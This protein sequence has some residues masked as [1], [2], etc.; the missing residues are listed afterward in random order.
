M[1]VSA[2]VT[3]Y[4]EL[5]AKLRASKSAATE[6]L[7]RNV[8]TAADGVVSQANRLTQYSVRIPIT[9]TSL[10]PT[11]ARITTRGAGTSKDDDIGAVIENRGKGDVRHPTFGNRHKWT[12]KNSHPEFM[13]AAL[14]ARER[15]SHDLITSSLIEALREVDL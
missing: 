3:S 4:G 6:A 9:A 11:L 15:Q 7:R 13:L 2:D 12:S 14:H 1:D 8:K 5:I 10:T